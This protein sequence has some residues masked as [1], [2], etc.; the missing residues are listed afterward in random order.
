VTLRDQMRGFQRAVLAH[1]LAATGWNVSA[2]ARSLG[3][4][5]SYLWRLMRRYGLRRPVTV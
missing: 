4:Q 1:H 2:A 5:S 3:I